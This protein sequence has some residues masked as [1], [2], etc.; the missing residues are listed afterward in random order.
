MELSNTYRIYPCG[1]QAITLE[2]G[3]TIDQAIN[4]RV[5][6]LFHFLKE[7]QLPLVKDIIPSYHTLTVVYDLLQVK[8]LT[9]AGTV[10]DYMQTLLQRALQDCELQPTASR[11]I[12]VPV[13]Y[14][15]AFSPDLAAVADAHGLSVPEVIELHTSRSYYVYL[16]GF[17]P[18]FAYM[19][20]VDERIATP[21]RSSPRT[22]VVAGSVGI[23][24][25]Q[26]GIYP[27]DSPGGWQLLGRTP[28]R[29]FDASRAEPA[30]LHPGDEVQFYPIDI[31]EYNT[32]QQHGHPH[33]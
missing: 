19:G 5:I 20:S 6:S 26:T 7:K 21:R 13:C 31:A 29:M 23:A 3:N 30:L 18:G 24:G 8:K 28:L 15:D 9:T 11:K 32:L 10:F 4:R 27:F 2:L 16:I 12:R 1:D 22:A 17:L 25:E 33:S 14:D